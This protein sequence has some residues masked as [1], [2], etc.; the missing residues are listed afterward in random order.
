M[1][2]IIYT[3]LFLNV[4]VIYAAGGVTQAPSPTV[5]LSGSGQEM[6]LAQQI[7]KSM[8]AEDV[9]NAPPQNFST[10]E[11]G[12]QMTGYE[13]EI[14]TYNN[15]INKAFKQFSQATANPGEKAIAYVMFKQAQQTNL[16]LQ[17]QNSLLRVMT[18]VNDNLETIIA[19]NNQALAGA[20]QHVVQKQQQPSRQNSMMVSP[21]K[22]PIMVQ[23][24][25]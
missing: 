12:N 24:A 8:P 15:A 3:L 22:Q 11:I 13:T 9:K 7:N 19:Q 10:S 17:Q 20:Q 4:S 6:S 23:E 2:K 14:V 16:L 21:Q 25:N 1:K 5:F 18:E